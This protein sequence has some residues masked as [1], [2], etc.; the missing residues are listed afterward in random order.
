[1]ALNIKKPEA[2]RLAQELAAETGE[3]L[4]EAVTVA[5]RERLSGLRRRQQRS[6][7]RAEVAD[8]QAFVASLP[9][10]DVRAA[11]EIIGYDEQ[12]LPG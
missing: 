9:D 10:V 12:G 5:L 6:R 3:S 1:M 2:E 11:D 4:T 7:V 8:L